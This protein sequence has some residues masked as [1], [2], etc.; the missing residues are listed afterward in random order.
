MK[1]ILSILILLPVVVMCYAQSEQSL[2]DYLTNNA[3]TLNPIEGVYDVEWNCDYVTPFVHQQYETDHFTL[4]IKSSGGNAFDV[5][6]SY[7]SQ[8]NY[9][10]SPYLRI[11]QI[12]QT[13]VYYFYY[14]SSKCR[15]Y[16]TDNNN[17]FVAKLLLDNSS[18]KKFTEN[19][20]LAPSVHVYPVYDCIKTY[21]TK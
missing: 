14:L 11:T 3:S 19:S 18:A 16:L 1:K 12:G 9:Q 5:Y 10:K 6:A 7:A 20:S 8:R 4:I 21:P 17:H 13:N 15:V 2:R